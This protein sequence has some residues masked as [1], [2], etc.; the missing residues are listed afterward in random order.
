LID[1]LPKQKVRKIVDTTKSEYETFLCAPENLKKANKIKEIQKTLKQ[2]NLEL[3][4]WY[5]KWS[6]IEDKLINI[7]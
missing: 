3:E 1:G 6:E 4:H 2:V 7:N 5:H